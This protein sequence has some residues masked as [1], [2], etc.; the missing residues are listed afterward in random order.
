MMGM[1][2]IAVVS[3]ETVVPTTMVATKITVV[4][5]PMSHK[6]MV[7]T[8]TAMMAGKTTVVTTKMS[9]AVSA[10]ATV[11]KTAGAS[12]SRDQHQ[13]QP[14]NHCFQVHASPPKR[15]T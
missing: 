7:P 10:M 11:A 14:E 4:K 3:V 6:F 1:V 15:E 2:A 9:T 12:R 13:G 5:L 8:K